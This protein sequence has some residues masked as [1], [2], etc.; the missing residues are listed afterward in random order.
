MKAKDLDSALDAMAFLVDASEMMINQFD[1][2]QNQGFNETSL[3]QL[4]ARVEYLRV[5]LKNVRDKT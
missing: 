3:I 5:A 4:T 1:S 2:A